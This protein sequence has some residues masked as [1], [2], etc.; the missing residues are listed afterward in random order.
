MVI[1]ALSLDEESPRVKAAEGT[2]ADGAITMQHTRVDQQP[3]GWSCHDLAS[4]RAERD[5]VRRPRRPSYDD[6][7]RWPSAADGPMVRVAVTRILA[8]RASRRTTG[9]AAPGRRPTAAR[10][11]GAVRRGRA[12]RAVARRAARVSPR[13]RS[14][15]QSGPVPRRPHHG[16]VAVTAALAAAALIMHLVWSS[17]SSSSDNGDAVTAY[18]ALTTRVTADYEAWKAT[19]HAR[20]TH[21]LESRGTRPGPSSPGTTSE[22]EQAHGDRRQ[23]RAGPHQGREPTAAAVHR[24]DGLV[25]AYAHATALKL[26]V[27][28]EDPK[29]VGSHHEFASGSVFGLA[30]VYAFDRRTMVCVGKV[31]ATS[32]AKV[33][34]HLDGA[35]AELDDDLTKNLRAAVAPSLRAAV[36]VE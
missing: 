11:S 4:E 8:H 25:A 23:P 32:S 19:T 24:L 27:V 10:G 26:D 14:P 9:T 16:I 15:R 5:R 13:H 30:Y 29:T 1:N 33:M 18:P 31:L 36:H 20:R 35:G 21:R 28:T 7:K 34:V 12:H 22:L 3:Q 6:T 17:S 2:A